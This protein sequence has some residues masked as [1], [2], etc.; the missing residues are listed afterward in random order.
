MMGFLNG[1]LVTED[2]F[3]FAVQFEKIGGVSSV[4]DGF[5]LA[6]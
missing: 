2:S 3:V 1:Y 4:D 5:E 6:L